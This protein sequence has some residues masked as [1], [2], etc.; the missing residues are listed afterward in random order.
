MIC[1]AALIIF[2]ILGI[3]SVAYRKL[4]KEAFA[5]VLRRMSFRPCESRFDLKVKTQIA[6]S[7]MKRSEKLGQFFWKYFEVFSWIFVVLFII[8]TFYTA[9]G[10]YNLIRYKTCDP[11]HPQNCFISQ[12]GASASPTECP[13]QQFQNLK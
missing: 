7:L 10:A 13:I 2:A 6:T 8:S 9:R 12:P 11:Q 1:L 4:A 5:C 3:F